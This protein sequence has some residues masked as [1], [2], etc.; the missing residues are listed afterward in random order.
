MIKQIN[1]VLSKLKT[2]YSKGTIMKVRKEASDL[3]KIFSRHIFKKKLVFRKNSHFNSIIIKKQPFIGKD[4][5]G[6]FPK[7]VYR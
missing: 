6:H 5:N 7:K 1:R 3:E 2:C 4:L